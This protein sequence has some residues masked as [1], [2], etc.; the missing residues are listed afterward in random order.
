M[1]LRTR[2][3][4]AVS[5]M[6]MASIFTSYLGHLMR[7]QENGIDGFGYPLT[8]PNQLFPSF[9]HF[10]AQQIPGISI[11]R[12]VE[13]ICYYMRCSSQAYIF[14]LAYIR[15]LVYAGF[16]LHAKSI[17]RV[18][19]TSIVIAAKTRDDHSYSMKFYAQMGGVTNIDLNTM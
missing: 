16:P 6:R 3:Q 2:Q 7:I 15:R 1:L 5:E 17:H 4:R 19:L 10:C 11:E 14:A 12:Y 9:D 13:R 18:V 8:Q